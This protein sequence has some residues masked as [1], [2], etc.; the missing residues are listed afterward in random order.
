MKKF[1]TF[2]LT[3]IFC[4]SFTNVVCAKAVTFDDVNETD[5]YYHDLSYLVEKDVIHG[6][7]ATEFAPDRPITRGEFVTVLSAAAKVDV[8]GF[9]G[10]TVFSDVSAADWYG[11]N[12]Q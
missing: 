6:L 4:F 7:S 9:S 10:E 3:L 1:L 5:W 8:S 12:V 11:K 2:I